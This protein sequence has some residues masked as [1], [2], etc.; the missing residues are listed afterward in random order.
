MAWI[1]AVALA[2]TA[3]STTPDQPAIVVGSGD[4]TLS[5]VLAEIF[6]GALA[7]TGA[8]VRTEPE[9]GTRTEYL[10][11]LDAARVTVVPEVSGDLLTHYVP[12]SSAAAPDDVYRELNR[13]LPQ[14][15]SVTDY[16]QAQLRM[17]VYARAGGKIGQLPCTSTIVV[18]DGAVDP[19]G[20]VVR[21]AEIER[22]KQTY[23]CAFA[24]L[25][26][27]ASEVTAPVESGAAQAALVPFG[28]PAPGLVPLTDD[29][30]GLVSRN[31]L[32]LFRTGSLTKTQI[33]KLN[34]VSGELTTSG[35]ADVVQQAASA[36][37]AD[38][39]R[40]WLDAHGL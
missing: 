14:G 25:P 20:T 26:V 17:Q 3:C 9:L 11:A 21:P 10:A 34:Y 8:P 30:N 32:P 12:E 33:V 23:T 1:A 31:V 39:A 15:L 2:A 37:P 36:P 35:L 22:L 6:A 27:P 13:A 40:A 5:R 19:A 18:V 29:R 24:A 7:R 16:A 38:V 4:S 28:V